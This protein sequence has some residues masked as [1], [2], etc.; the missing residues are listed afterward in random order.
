MMLILRKTSNA[1]PMVRMASRCSY[2]CLGLY[3]CGNLMSLSSHFTTTCFLL[4]FVFAYS[5]MKHN[6]GIT[7][8]WVCG[9][10]F[11]L[12]KVPFSVP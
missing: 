8:P 10:H 6:I 9:F 3:V 4:L 1:C 7:D 11:F 5:F 12:F 2:I